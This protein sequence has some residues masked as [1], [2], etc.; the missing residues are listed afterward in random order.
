VRNCVVL[1]GAKGPRLDA[2]RDG[3]LESGFWVFLAHDD[4]E[5][6]RLLTAIRHDVCV[7]DAASLHDQAWELCKAI[8]AVPRLRALPLVVLCVRGGRPRGV[9]QS[10]AARFRCTTLT[11]RITVEDLVDAVATVVACPAPSR[12]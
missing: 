2:Y 11:G 12:A 10:R 6:L 8:R 7:I 1:I 9:L 5:G 4:A 3:L